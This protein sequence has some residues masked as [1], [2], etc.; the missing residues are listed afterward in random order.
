MFSHSSASI[1]YVLLSIE[2]AQQKV[3]FPRVSRLSR[4]SPIVLCVHPRAAFAIVFY[5]FFLLWCRM[6]RLYM[7]FWRNLNQHSLVVFMLL[8]LWRHFTG[9]TLWMMFSPYVMVS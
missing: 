6:K 4:S 9:R 2:K 7:C 8:F 1:Q 3:I 5:E